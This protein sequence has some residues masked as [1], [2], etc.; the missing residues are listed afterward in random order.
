M[1]NLINFWIVKQEWNQG[2]C[3]ILYDRTSHVKLILTL[4]TPYPILTSLDQLFNL[5]Y[6]Q[7]TKALFRAVQALTAL[8]FCRYLLLWMVVAALWK[9]RLIQNPK[10]W[11]EHFFLCFE[12][13]KNEKKLVLAHFL[14]N[15]F[16]VSALRWKISLS[17]DSNPCVWLAPWRPVRSVGH[18]A[19]TRLWFVRCCCPF[20]N[21]LIE[22][23]LVLLLLLLLLPLLLLLLP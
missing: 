15:V 8:N 17:E 11:F 3:Y 10:T 2:F 20:S 21:N 22:H 5:F 7:H 6:L 1:E 13:S 18:W 16:E 14:Q 19:D 12:R 23:M 4:T 9:A